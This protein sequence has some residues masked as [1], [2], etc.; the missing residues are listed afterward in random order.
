MVE[1]VQQSM[2]SIAHTV[3]EK[4]PYQGGK[5][6][7]LPVGIWPHFIWSGRSWTY[8]VYVIQIQ[9]KKYIL[10]S[11]MLEI[12]KYRVGTECWT[13]ALRA[14]NLQPK[15]V[16]NQIAPGLPC[17]E[18]FFSLHSTHPVR[19]FAKSLM[20]GRKQCWVNSFLPTDRT[21]IEPCLFP[22]LTWWLVSLLILY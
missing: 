9:T 6:S 13:C 3:N 10:L 15:S 12:L 1:A 20:K 7:V 21:K 18:L 5:S 11:S 16:I 14:V 4:F 2:L 22:R 17:S 8:Y 19:D